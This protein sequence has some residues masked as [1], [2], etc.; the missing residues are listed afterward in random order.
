[1]AAFG[2]GKSENSKVHNSCN[3]NPETGNLRLEDPI[4]TCHRHISSSLRFP[5]SGF[6]LQELC[7]FE[8]SDF[9]ISS[10]LRVTFTA[11]TESE[12]RECGLLP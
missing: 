6:E 10:K 8:F 12:R 3:S 5:I 9:P 7:T 2:I 4:G 1:M 11:Q